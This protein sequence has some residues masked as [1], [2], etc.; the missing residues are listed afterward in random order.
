MIKILLIE[1]DLDLRDGLTD[2]LTING[3]SVT[4]AA[5]GIEG[6]KKAA[7]VIPDLIISD[8]MMPRLDGFGLKELINENADLSHVPFIFLSARSEL[9]SIREGMDLAADDYITKPFDMPTLLSAIQRRLERH[10]T[11]AEK[12]TS[13]KPGN[14]NMEKVHN[15]SLDDKLFINLH[16]KTPRVIRISS[17]MV[18]EASG[19]YSKIYLS[20]GSNFLYRKSVSSWEESLNKGT[21]IRIHRSVI[22]NMDYIEKISRWTSGTYLVHIKG[23]EKTFTISQRYASSIRSQLKL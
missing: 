13:R 5:D 21:F 4:S 10:R 23:L 3:Y 15:Y 8:V 17:I 18:I 2:L 9:K 19:S 7:E 12:T 6:L 14:E 22:I 11:I 1:D 16:D 20:E